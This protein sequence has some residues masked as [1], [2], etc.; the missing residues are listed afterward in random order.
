[1]IIAGLT[2]LFAG[3]AANATVLLTIGNVLL[4][5]GMVLLM[6][7]LTGRAVGGRRHFY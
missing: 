6:L 2:L 7:G 5:V 4:I 3:M 1:M